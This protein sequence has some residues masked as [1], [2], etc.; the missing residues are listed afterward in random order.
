MYGDINRFWFSKEQ[1]RCQLKTAD[2]SN[3]EVFVD[4]KWV[5]F[6]QWTTSVF[7]KSNWEDAVLVAES[8]ID[9]PVRV[10]GVVQ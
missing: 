8:R 5:K 9:L 1:E 7:G 6:T 10:N 3:C 2:P 4:G